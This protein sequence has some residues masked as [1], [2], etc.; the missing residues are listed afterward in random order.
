MSAS[1]D[2]RPAR[3]QEF[4]VAWARLRASDPREDAAELAHRLARLGVPA[5]QALIH[6]SGVLAELKPRSRK[7]PTGKRPRGSKSKSKIK[8]NPPGRAAGKRSPPRGRRAK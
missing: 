6:V 4:G 5:G 1:S 7:A 8:S 2:D 3:V